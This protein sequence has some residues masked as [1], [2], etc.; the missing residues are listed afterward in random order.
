MSLNPGVKRFDLAI[1]RGFEFAARLAKIRRD[2]LQ[3]PLRR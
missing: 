2:C 3:Q 1:Q